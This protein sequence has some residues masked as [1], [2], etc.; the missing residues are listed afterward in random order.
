MPRHRHR[1]QAGTPLPGLRHVATAAAVAS[2]ALAVATPVAGLEFGPADAN[3]RLA[4]DSVPD[5][6]DPGDDGFD[7]GL[8]AAFADEVDSGPR[9]E[10]VLGT[11]LVD[12]AGL[13][14]ATEGAAR[15]VA[16]EQ[17]RIAR[18]TA[19]RVR[20]ATDD[21]PR[22][23][24]GAGRGGPSTA[25]CDADTSGLG[26]VQSWVSD[27]AEFLSCAYDQPQL[28]G[29]GERGN[30]SDHPSGHALDLMVRGEKG[31]RIA[32]CALANADEL[33]VK[34]VIWDQ[35]MNHGSGWS[36]M[37][38]RGGDT[39]NHKDHVHIS[40]ENSS[41]SGDPDLGKCA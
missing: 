8:D 3:F 11:D 32:E 20:S 28:L 34:Y 1:A 21:I 14:E 9:T 25:S 29:V 24:E 37:E 36:D 39:A 6:S 2:G 10:P 13:F 33:G 27:A 17:E 30:A 35:Q 40:F 12:A 16:D 19:E 26:A 38:D 7:V 4:A 15:A 23:G 31:D 22:P 41:G 5:G 18:E